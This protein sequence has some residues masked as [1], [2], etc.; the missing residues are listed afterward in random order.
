LAE[1][2]AHG[3]VGGIFALEVSRLARSSADWLARD[4]PALWKAKTTTAAERKNLLRMLVKQVTVSPIEVPRLAT[5]LQ[6][7]W[8]TG[9]VSDL[10]IPRP[11]KYTVFHTPT[12]ALELIEQLW[13][14]KV[15]DVD[16]AEQLN[17]RRLRT[18][19]GRRWT[20]AAVQRQ[21]YAHGWHLD[22]ARSR[23]ACS[24]GAL[25]SVH[26]VAQRIG[27]PV[28]I[29]RYWVTKGW[30]VPTE[31]GGGPGRPLLF[32]LDQEMLRHLG[33]LKAKRERQAGQVPSE[34]QTSC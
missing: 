3:R 5:R 29:V 11:S 8:Q 24:R 13:R 34:R 18:G 30:L 20:V 32:A 19:K 7:L 33:T 25:H 22:S 2:V 23:P 6:V 28:G 4:L 27:V 21:R 14:K 17:Q 9:S 31:G 10:E 1:D 15:P 26:G 16:I 12:E